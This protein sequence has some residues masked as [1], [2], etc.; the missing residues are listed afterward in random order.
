MIALTLS[1]VLAQ[2]GAAG[3][4]DRVVAR[5]IQGGVFP[6]AVVIVGRRDSILL[7]RGYGH[8]TW[9]PRSPAPDPDS[10]LYDLASLTKVVATTPSIMLLV[11]RGLVQLDRPVQ[12]YLPEFAGTGKEDV[13]VWNLLAHNSG[14]RSFL[15]LD[16]L[17]RDSST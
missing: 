5:G 12:Y 16:T 9:S 2:I 1:V 15:R 8:L 17:A 7:E 3:E 4:I 13:T 14:L 11:E 6:G 10:T